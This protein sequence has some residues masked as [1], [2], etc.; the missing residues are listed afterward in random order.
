MKK[1]DQQFPNSDQLEIATTAM[2]SVDVSKLPE[3]VIRKTSLAMVQSSRKRRKH[4]PVLQGSIVALVALLLLV[5]TGVIG[6]TNSSLA[7][8]EVARQVAATKTL[9]AVVIF[10]TDGRAK[11]FVADT[12]RRLEGEG[13]ITIANPSTGRRVQL[14]TKRKLAYRIGQPGM[15]VAFD[16]YGTFRNL[17]AAAS[18]PIEEFVDKAGQRYPGFSGKTSLS[19]GGG[20]TW[21]V[22]VK[23]WSNPKTKLPVRLEIKPSEYPKQTMVVE[24]LEFDV[25]LD[26]AI[27]DMTIPKDYK[28]VG[29]SADELKPPPSEKEA[30]KLTI[31][32]GVGLGEVKFGMTRKQIV[33]VLGEPEFTLHD[34][35]LC[36]PSKG[37]QLVLVG[38]EPDKLGT[39]IANPMDASMLTRNEFPGQT[40]KGIRIGSTLKQIRNAYGEPDVV[41]PLGNSNPK[42]LRSASYGQLGAQ[43]HFWEGKVA[44]IFANRLPVKKDPDQLKPIVRILTNLKI[45]AEGEGIQIESDVVDLAAGIE[46]HHTSY[47]GL[48]FEYRAVID[49]K[50]PSDPNSKYTPA[51]VTNGKLHTL[52]TFA[53]LAPTKPGGRPWR[54]WVRKVKDANGSW[55]LDRGVSFDGTKS[56]TFRKRSSRKLYDGVAYDGQI[57]PWED[58]M[59]ISADRFDEMLFTMLNGVG[60]S[61]PVTDELRLLNLNSFHVKSKSSSTGQEIITLL[62][63]RDPKGFGMKYRT[64]MTGQPDCMLLEW[65]AK[66]TKE[67]DRILNSYKIEEVKRFRNISYPA[68]G[69]YHQASIGG[70]TE[71]TYEFEVISVQA[72]DSEKRKHWMLPWPPGT[73]GRDYITN[74]NFQTKAE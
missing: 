45:L 52:N 74:K 18:T 36:Y 57:L 25:S 17:A 29:L 62:G 13:T 37:L 27:F 15:G 3:E 2:Q 30:A 20:K 56:H 65:E 23:V 59:S 24:Q 54:S 4:I 5:I 10:P 32:L 12:R 43:F 68:R 51:G 31:E 47:Y 33:A 35:Y 38:R 26:D 72:I 55:V 60:A 58:G 28:I 70:T 63:Q 44:Q 53:I 41:L 69:H 49:V 19:L 9:R 66:Y 48:Q 11:L 14:D 1:N 42:K 6:Q 22:E 39:I 67:N 34:S 73:A 7:F 64:K 16:F 50:P 71:Q 61:Q 46:K 40:G 21:D 8:T